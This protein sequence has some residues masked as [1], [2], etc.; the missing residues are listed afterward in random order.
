MDTHDKQRIN[1][2]KLKYLHNYHICKINLQFYNNISWT[3]NLTNWTKNRGQTLLSIRY[4]SHKWNSTVLRSVCIN[5]LIREK[6]LFS[7]NE[8]EG[9]KFA[10][11][12][13]MFHETAWTTYVLEHR[14]GRIPKATVE[15]EKYLVTV[16]MYRWGGTRY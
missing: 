11:D 8:R 3:W 1:S 15:E 7:R 6:F 9:I 12:G 13:S 10:R 14:H 5:Y 4:N 2:I 16:P